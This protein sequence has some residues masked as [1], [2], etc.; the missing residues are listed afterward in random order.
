MSSVLRTEVIDIAYSVCLEVQYS[1][2]AELITVEPDQGDQPVAG[3]GAHRQ[4]LFQIV[5]VDEAKSPGAANP[6]RAS[7]SQML[8]LEFSQGQRRDVVQRGRDRGLSAMGSYPAQERA[9]Y[10]GKGSKYPEK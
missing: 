8:G 2:R 4:I 5:G 1:H 10:G 7:V 6:D 3:H 9:H